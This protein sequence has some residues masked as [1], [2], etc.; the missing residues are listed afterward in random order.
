MGKYEAKTKPTQ[1]SVFDF[2]DAIENPVRRD[3]ARQI[4]AMMRRVSGEQPRLWGPSIIGY[5]A[6]HYRYASGHEGDAPRIGF[7]PRK[8]ELVLYLLC[9]ESDRP[10]KAHALL[11]RLGKHRTSVSCLYVRRLD[12]VDLAVLEELA[13]L[14]WEEM[15]KRYPA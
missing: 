7:S 1:E 12:Q 2:I 8:A 14:S 10:A 13:E 5:G 11:A 3:E 15:A 6:Y 9:C 4:D